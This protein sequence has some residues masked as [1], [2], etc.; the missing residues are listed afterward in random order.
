MIP[1]DDGEIQI[2]TMENYDRDQHGELTYYATG[3]DDKDSL[4][5]QTVDLVTNQVVKYGYYDRKMTAAL[6]YNDTD[7]VLKQEIFVCDD[8]GRLIKD[9]I[10]YKIHTNDS[11]ES[12]IEYDKQ[13]DNPLADNTISK[14]KYYVN[15]DLTATTQN[16]YDT[17]KRI[18]VKN[19]TVGNTQFTKSI[20]YDK[21]RVEKVIDSACGTT[22]YEYDAMG[23]ITSI[24]NSNPITYE[25][26]SFGQLVRENNKPLD[27]TLVY[28]YDSIGN[29]TSVKTYAYTPQG[30]NVSGSY[31]E[32]TFTYNP[33]I[34]DRL[35]SYGGTGISYNSMG[36]PTSYD[37]YT[38]LWT[39]GKLSR[40]SKGL[41]LTGTHTSSFSYNGLGQRTGRSYV[42]T[43]GTA[44][45]SEVLMGM[46]LRSNRVYHYD[47]C[48]RLICESNTSEYHLEESTFENVV[49]LYDNNS[50]I[51]MVYTGYGET[52]TYYFDRNLQGDV[53]GIYDTN[54]TRVAGY[55]YDAFGNCS[56]TSDTTKLSVAHAN[57]FRYRGYYYDEDTKLYYL[58]SRYYSPEWRRFI[59]PDDTS[60]LDPETPNGLNLYAYCNNDPVNYADPSGN[61]ATWV[62]ALIGLGLG[63]GLGIGVTAFVDSQDDN[64]VNGS[65]GFNSYLRNAAI[66]GSFG[67]VGGYLYGPQILAFISSLL[68]SSGATTALALAS[69][70]VVEIA[71][72]GAVVVGGVVAVELGIMLFAKP[73]TGPIRFSDGTGIDP[74]TG[75]PVTDKERAYEIYRALEN[76][77]QKLNWKKWIK[78]K[79]WRTH[80]LK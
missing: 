67:L 15:G 62:L 40:L 37:G 72:A 32:K 30:T 61:L 39:R 33:N 65:I 31:T 6:T 21:T 22:L 78:G 17:Y 50:V 69:G 23:R 5:A 49:Y 26:D 28:C 52:N 7:T 24:N 57:S 27:K 29:I 63:I 10:N 75:K 74:L 13:A 36:C 11:V 71:I 38:T 70:E 44:N 12:A 79:G 55:A 20:E 25:Y 42:Y 66:L 54:G 58:N 18:S 4:L 2:K 43:Q 53:I 19:Y 80:H 59:S 56:I 3:I 45:A 1:T 9:Q 41:K 68:G 16:T 47:S 48:G 8:I 64:D 46:L 51:G 77:K 76:A 34:P 14:Y 73:N 60:Y 35:I